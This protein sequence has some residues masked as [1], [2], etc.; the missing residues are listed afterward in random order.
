MHSSAITYLNGSSSSMRTVKNRDL[1]RLMFHQKLF[2]NCMPHVYAFP[3]H[4]H[5]AS[6]FYI[7]SHHRRRGPHAYYKDS[8]YCNEDQSGLQS[9]SPGTDEMKP[10]VMVM[11]MVSMKVRM[12]M[13]HRKNMKCQYLV[14]IQ[15]VSY[16]QHL[17]CGLLHI[18]KKSS[19]PQLHED[20][21]HEE[22]RHEQR[23]Y[24]WVFLIRSNNL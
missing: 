17:K 5:Q 11:V 15:N 1:H 6:A 21:M 3:S 9:I 12:M 16:A 2:L 24:T 23:Q 14:N 18:K 19:E 22:L 8:S 10:E 4:F 13:M 7:L 20:L